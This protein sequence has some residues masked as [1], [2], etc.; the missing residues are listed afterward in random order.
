MQLETGSR[1]TYAIYHF[2]D[3]GYL[4][5]FAQFEEGNLLYETCYYTESADKYDDNLIMPP[6]LSE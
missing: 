2:D 3:C 6:L 5:T 1:G 4:I